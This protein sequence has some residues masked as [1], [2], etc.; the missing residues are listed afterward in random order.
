M[1]HSIKKTGRPPYGMLAVLMVGAFIA[2][3]NNTLLNIALPSI[4]ADLKV[5]ASTVQWLTTGFM[6]VNGILIPATAF[7]I[8]KY[9][10]RRL[11]LAA[12]LLFTI[13]T[14]VAG[15]AHT[16]PLL[17]AGRML[18]ASGSA[19]MMPLLMNVM[20]VSFPVE[21]RGAAMGVFG[22]ILMAAP[23][24][25]P[26]LSGWIIEHY[27]W[28]MLFHFVTPIAIIV[29]LLGFF[30]LKDKKEKVD[31]HLDIF[32]LLLS[33]IGFG[34]ILYGFSSAG[35][36]GWDSPLVY[37]TIAIGVI[38]LVWFI[39]RQLKLERPMLNFGIFKY[40]MF[41]LSSSITMVVN[42]A[43]FAGML[44]IPIY[45]QTI[46]GISPM[47]AGLMMLPGALLMA[48]MSPITGKLFDKFGG[49][50]LAVTG[51]IIMT[52]TT[53]YFSQL[54]EETTYTYLVILNSVRM[55]GMSMVMMPVSTNGLNQLPTRFYPHGTAMNN[56]LNQVAG[57]IGTALL[58]TV[59]STRT[60]T[61]ATS[62]AADAMK[63]ATGQPTEAAIAEMQQQIA[64][65]AMLEGI[66][67][68]FLVATFIAAVAVILALFIKRAKQAEDPLQKKSTD[69]KIAAK[70]VEN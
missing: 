50:I 22:L 29:L 17:L 51:L 57:A 26:T 37:G 63:H 18:Q 1:D 2:F 13:G 23:A 54:T 62:L 61:H 31:I 3:L 30:L 45:V 53:Y 67:D 48:V 8:E 27:D 28:R 59:M 35:S 7:L 64:M 69:E 52:V 11:F 20:L 40:P 41:A 46:R 44:L 58:V 47:D 9:S 38:S 60:E 4:M 36:K 70:L 25:G 56:T 49:R 12:M 39:L 14:L 65:K 19:V 15:I 42:M 10:V 66:N 6:L 33:S 32:S 55:F 34:G 5:E 68:A 43:M 21:K 16:F 24:I